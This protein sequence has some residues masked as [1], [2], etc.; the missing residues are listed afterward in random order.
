MAQITQL[1]PNAL[2]GR[3]YGTF[4][5]G[6]LPI[7]EIWKMILIPEQYPIANDCDSVHRVSYQAVG[8]SIQVK[9]YTDS[10]SNTALDIT[11]GSSVKLHLS[12]PSGTLKTKTA[13]IKDATNGIIEYV[14]TVT[15]DLDEV[16]VWK[17]QGEITLSGSTRRTLNTPVFFEVLANLS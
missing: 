9:F 16:G 14:T 8:V 7:V 10:V 5:T 11:G 13:T 12:P 1:H 6:A 3:R 17:V 15:D 2:P 4:G